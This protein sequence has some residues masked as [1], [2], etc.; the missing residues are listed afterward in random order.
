MTENL[1][2]KPGFV[3]QDVVARITSSDGG[4]TFDPSTLKILLQ[5]DDPFANHNGGPIAFGPDGMFY[6]GI[7]DGGSGGAPEGN[8]QNKDVLLGKLLRIAPHGG[9]PYG[10]PPTNPFAAGGGRPEIMRTAFATRGSSASTCSP[11]PSG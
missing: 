4:A 6:V 9:E 8:G 1:A 5:V 7:G 3:F 11:A 10:I 2:N